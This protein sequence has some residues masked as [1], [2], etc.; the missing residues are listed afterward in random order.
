MRTLQSGVTIFFFLPSLVDKQQGSEQEF[1]SGSGE[2]WEPDLSEFSTELPVVLW[3]EH[4][5]PAGTRRV[6]SPELLGQQSA[7]S[8]GCE[9]LGKKDY[10]NE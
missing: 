1:G 4:V 6:W 2:L 7:N 10:L 3:D 5:E 8:C 9:D